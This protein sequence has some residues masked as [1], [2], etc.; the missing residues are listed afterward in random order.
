[1]RDSYRILALFEPTGLIGN[2]GLD[3]FKMGNDFL[4]NNPPNLLFIPRTI[5]NE[6]LQPLRINTKPGR[7]RFNGLTLPQ[8]ISKPET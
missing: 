3:R 8:A 4:A 1:M 7:H 6:L 5:G 2:P